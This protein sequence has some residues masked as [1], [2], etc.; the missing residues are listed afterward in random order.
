M[1]CW[2]CFKDTIP[3]FYSEVSNWVL[4]KDILIKKKSKFLT[5]GKEFNFI[6][7]YKDKQLESSY[8]LIIKLVCALLALSHFGAA[9]E[10]YFLNSNLSKMKKESI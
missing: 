1:S 9:I 4:D 2:C 10:C 8:P 6:Q 3:S 7:Y 5:K